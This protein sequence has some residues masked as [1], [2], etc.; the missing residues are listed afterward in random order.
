MTQRPIP[1]DKVVKDFDL[2]SSESYLPE[3]RC[4]ASENG[5]TSFIRVGDSLGA[6]HCPGVGYR[7]RISLL[8]VEISISQLTNPAIHRNVPDFK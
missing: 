6:D 7:S 3:A 1:Q 5:T 2:I 8:H 4:M